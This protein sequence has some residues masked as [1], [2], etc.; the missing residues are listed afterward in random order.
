MLD[1]TV[2]LSKWTQQTLAPSSRHAAQTCGRAALLCLLLFHEGVVLHLDT[3]H[4]LPGCTGEIHVHFWDTGWLSSITVPA[5]LHH[6]HNTLYVASQ[7][8]IK[9]PVLHTLTGCYYRCTVLCVHVESDS[10]FSLP[11]VGLIK[12]LRHFI[13]WLRRNSFP[14][15]LDLFPRAT[16]RAVS[17]A[18][19]PLTVLISRS[20]N[21][22]FYLNLLNQRST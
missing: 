19:S 17:A 11:G 2:S 10:S 16:L 8:Y 14:A 21:H 4:Q 7:K 1:S 12:R 13:V 9:L 3:Y 5:C 18:F 15:V 22:H 6:G 20:L